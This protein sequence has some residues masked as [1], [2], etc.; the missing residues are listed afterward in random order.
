MTE[1]TREELERARKKAARRE[2][3]ENKK[4]QAARFWNENKEAI[5]ILT[6]VVITAIGGLAKSASKSANNREERRLKENYVWDARTGSYWELNKPLT[7]YEQLEFEERRREGEPTGRILQ[8]MG[9]L[10]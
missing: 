3:F 8:S 9:K 5:C 10:R 1:I 4:S 6:P 2:W 7:T